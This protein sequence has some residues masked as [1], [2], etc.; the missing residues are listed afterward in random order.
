ME[1]NQPTASVPQEKPADLA[2]ATAQETERA[3][4]ASTQALKVL[5]E[6]AQGTPRPVVTAGLE[7]LT[8][9][10]RKEELRVRQEQ[11]HAYQ[12]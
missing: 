5:G 2:A 1:G 11:G 3:D 4:A 9:Q 10:D 8:E 7:V 6:V 12:R